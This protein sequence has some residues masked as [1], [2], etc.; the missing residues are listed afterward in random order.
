MRIE[1]NRVDNMTKWSKGRLVVEFH[2][3]KLKPW[4]VR[5]NKMFAYCRRRIELMIVD[6]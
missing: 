1:I 2:V 3:W 6:G 5:F 4:H